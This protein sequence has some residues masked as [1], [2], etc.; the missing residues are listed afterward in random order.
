VEVFNYCFD[1]V[2]VRTRRLQIVRSSLLDVKVLNNIFMDVEVLYCRFRNIEASNYS[3]I[4]V[5]VSK[6]NVK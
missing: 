6:R 3:L 1:S 5:E 2:E 4:D